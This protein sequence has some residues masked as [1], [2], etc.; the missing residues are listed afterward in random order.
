MKF[1]LVILAIAL[2]AVTANAADINGK[3][4]A[5][6]SNQV[7]AKSER[8]FAFQVSGEKVT[9][10]I[11]E[12]QVSVATFEQIGKPEMSGI[13]K[14]RNRDPQAIHDGKINGD[15]ISFAVVTNTPFGEM[16]TEYKGMISG[17]EIKFTVE[18]SSGMG[19]PGGGGTPQEIVAKRM[20]P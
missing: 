15:S 4:V 1:H 5:Q 16:K 14:T 8:I 12:L 18:Q 11:T 9:G 7:G 13:L 10:T 6:V 17:G 3:W 2:C 19:G 20:K